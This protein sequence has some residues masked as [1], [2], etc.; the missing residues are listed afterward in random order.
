MHWIRVLVSE[1]PHSGIGTVAITQRVFL[2]ETT[3]IPDGSR[4]LLFLTS[5]QTNHPPN[6]G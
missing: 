6:E 5:P 1:M 4:N 2:S 3:A